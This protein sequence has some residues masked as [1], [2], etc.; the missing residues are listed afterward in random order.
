[1]N[2][3]ENAKQPPQVFY[4]LHMVPGVAEYRE[5][6]REPCR[7]LIE[8]EAIK[9]M[10]PTFQGR[11]VFVRHVDEVNLEN[12]QHEADGYVIESFYNEKDGKHWVKFIVVSDRGHEAIRNG[13]RLSNAYLPKEMTGGGLWHGVE[14]QKKITRGEYEHLAIVPNPRYDESVILTPDEFKSYNNEKELE[15]KKLAN[16]GDKPMKLNFFKKTKVENST[17]LEGTTVV[18]PKSGL[19]KTISQLVNEADEMEQKKNE[20]KDSEVMA[21]MDHSV[22]V[23][24]EKMKLNDLVKKYSDCMN[25]LAELKKSSADKAPDE[26]KDNASAAEDE[27]AKKKAL[28]LA[29]H[30]EKEIKEKKESDLDKEE[31]KKNEEEETKKNH[32]EALKNA[33]KTAIVVAPKFEFNEDKVARGKARYGSH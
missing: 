11:P 25:E 29:E 5:P 32:F 24:D 23:G 15:L 9:N 19:E 6:G 18:L 31:P 10:D 21:N 7:I 16:E 12:I 1:M 4:G 27:D 33:E 30:E 17:D 22:Q 26:E 28:E 3:V 14:Y 2:K 8:E 20:E 13:W